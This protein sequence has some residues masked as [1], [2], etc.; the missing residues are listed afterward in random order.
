MKA[1]MKKAKQLREQYE[2]TL[3]LHERDKATDEEEQEAWD[4]LAVFAHDHDL[5][6]YC[7]GHSPGYSY[8]NDCDQHEPGCVCPT[9][10][11]DEA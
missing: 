2:A 1:T 7:L 8:C 9:C 6:L 3:Y 4:A 11:P 5:C 10:D